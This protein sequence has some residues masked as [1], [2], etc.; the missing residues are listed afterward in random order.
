VGRPPL[1][2]SVARLP[3]ASLYKPA[4]IPTRELDQVGLTVDEVEAL[5]LADLDGLSHEQAAESLGVSRQ[6][7]GRVLE[8]AR[9]KVADALVNG[10]ALVIDGG[11]YQVSGVRCCEACGARWEGGASEAAEDHA[12]PACGSPRVRAC[13]G[14]GAGRGPGGGS[15]GSGAR[16]SGT[17]GGPGSRDPGPGSPGDPGPGSRGGCAGGGGPGRG[18]GRGP[19]R[20]GQGGRH[21]RQE[22]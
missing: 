2:R 10:K 19:G 7:V 18:G 6:T 1:E 14:P 12:C 11:S 9:R 8:S 21:G 22:D 3:R 17:P 15:P 5:R 4:G 16:D 20:R 13:V